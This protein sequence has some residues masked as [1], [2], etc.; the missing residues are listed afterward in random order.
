MNSCAKNGGAP[1]RRFS[2]IGEKPEGGVLKHPPA[3]RGLIR[4][5]KKLDLKMILFLLTSEIIIFFSRLTFPKRSFNQIRM[6]WQR[7]REN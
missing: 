2:A 5:Q 3:R 6:G 1:R 7:I 4:M